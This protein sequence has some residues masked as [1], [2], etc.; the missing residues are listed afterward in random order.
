ME[1]AVVE[2]VRNSSSSSLEAKEGGEPNW[3]AAKAH[4][5]SQIDTQTRREKRMVSQVITV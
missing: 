3:N 2:A 4:A 5:V 1:E